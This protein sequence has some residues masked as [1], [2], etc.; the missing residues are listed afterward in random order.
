MN[1]HAVSLRSPFPP[2]WPGVPSGCLSSNCLCWVVAQSARLAPLLWSTRTR[3]ALDWIGQMLCFHAWRILGGGDD[4]GVVLKHS[5]LTQPEASMT[6]FWPSQY[7]GSDLG[8][9]H[10][11]RGCATAVSTGLHTELASVGKERLSLCLLFFSS[12]G[13]LVHYTWH[14]EQSVTFCLCLLST[15]DLLNW[16]SLDATSASSL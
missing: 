2:A 9:A 14:L 13:G 6:W 10:S 11:F 16:T 1:L 3:A 7:F 15:W 8:G 5:P 4:F 12:R